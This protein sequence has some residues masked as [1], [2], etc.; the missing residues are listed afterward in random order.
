M[1]ITKDTS[2]EL[3]VSHRAD[4]E[5]GTHILPSQAYL[6]GRISLRKKLLSGRVAFG[7]RASRSAMR[8]LEAFRFVSEFHLSGT[9]VEVERASFVPGKNTGLERMGK[10][11]P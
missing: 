8:F 6:S 7:C 2:D 5:R 9:H 1:W 4:L 10:K 11:F 3:F